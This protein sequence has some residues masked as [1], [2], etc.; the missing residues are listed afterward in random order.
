MK[1]FQTFKYQLYLLQLEGYELGR[2]WALLFKKGYFF[3]NQSLRKEIVWTA[4]S[5]AILV[6]AAIIIFVIAFFGYLNLGYM[7]AGILVLI[8]FN[9][10]PVYYSLVLVAMSPIDAM[11]KSIII[12]RAK[13]ILA[14]NPQIKIIGIAGSYGKTTMKSVLQTVLAAKLKVGATPESVNTPVGISRWLTRE[15]KNNPEVLVI[16]MGEHYVGDIKYLCSIFPPD[17]AVVTGINEAHFERLG[18]IEAATKTIF[19]IVENSKEDTKIVLNADDKNIIKNYKNFV[20]EG[21]ASFYGSNNSDLME[22]KINKR[23]FDVQN[24][25]WKF[26]IESVG[27]FEINCLGEYIIGD[28]VA[29][30][31]VAESLGLSADEIR[32]GSIGIKPVE[33]R[34]QPIR[35]GGN[36]LVIDDSYNGNPDGV[37]EAIGLLSRFEGRRKIFLTP[38]LVETG[39]SNEKVHLEI[40]QNLSKVADL[41]IL[42]KNSASTY[43]EKGLLLEKFEANNIVWFDSAIEAHAALSGILKPNDVIIFQNDWGDQYL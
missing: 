3:S 12:T 7:F 9:I 2:F 32:R 42:I 15:I 11:F 40:G 26:E 20:R 1:I 23:E 10:L 29:A 25:K 30:T 17:I 33:H 43:I 31:S 36:V 28:M 8:S 13:K 4:K 18:T 5:K 16:E 21:S 14:D 39:E 19:E 41:V 24:L 34:L 35:S 27:S 38:G 6:G 22:Y 37:S